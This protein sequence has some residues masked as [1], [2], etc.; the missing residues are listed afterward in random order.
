LLSAADTKLDGTIKYYVGQVGADSYLVTDDDGI[1]YT[2]VIKLAGF[3]AA[4]A[5]GQIVA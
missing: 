3:T 2:D 5:V 1:G 4:F